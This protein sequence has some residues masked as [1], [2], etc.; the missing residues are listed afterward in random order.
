MAYIDLIKAESQS[1]QYQFDLDAKNP[2]LVAFTQKNVIKAE[3]MIASNSAYRKAANPKCG[4]KK[5]YRGSTAYWFHQLLSYLQ[6]SSTTAWS[7]AGNK[8]QLTLEKEAQILLAPKD[9]NPLAYLFFFLVSAID[10]E[11]STHVNADGSGRG[12]LAA[13]LYQ[14]YKAHPL[15]FKTDLK[16]IKRV[17][18]PTSIFSKLKARTDP[19][20]YQSELGPSFPKNSGPFISRSNVSFASKFCHYACFYLFPGKP[21]QDLYSICDGVLSG[22]L[23]RYCAIHGLKNTYPPATFS[24]KKT[25]FKYSVYLKAIETLAQ[26]FDKP[27]SRNGFDHLIWY[28]HKGRD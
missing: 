19:Q 4:P 2:N 16:D 12:E 6:G 5:D 28:F 21:E 13:R 3:A 23:P 10:R 7:G 20:G 11:N 14:R 9:R 1:K 17:D 26:K 22:A 24:Y 18:N 25:G 27:V 15:R 8:L